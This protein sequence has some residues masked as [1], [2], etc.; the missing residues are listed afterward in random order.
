MGHGAKAIKISAG[1]VSLKVLC[2]SR[3]A[4]NMGGKSL[5]S[6]DLRWE[7]WTCFVQSTGQKFLFISYCFGLASS[8]PHSAETQTAKIR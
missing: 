5:H 2:R 1:F 4:L 7:A 6:E 3:A 8:G